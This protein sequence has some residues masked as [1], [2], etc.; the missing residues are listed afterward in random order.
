MAR[1]ILQQRLPIA[2]VDA[3][4][5]QSIAWL[6]TGTFRLADLVGIDVL[7]HVAANF[8]QGITTGSF[9]SVLEEIVKRG[10]LGDK[11]GQGFYKKT[12]VADGKEQRLVLDL[13]TSNIAH[14]SKRRTCR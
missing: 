7:A 3:R 1:L 5:G 2:E 4:T 10:W 12:R 6:R 14:W 9:A 13:R 8:P 11:A